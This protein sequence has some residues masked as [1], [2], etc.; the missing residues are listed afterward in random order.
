[1]FFHLSIRTASGLTRYLK[2]EGGGMWIIISIMKFLWKENRIVKYVPE[3]DG[4]TDAMKDLL[5]VFKVRKK[6]IEELERA[7]N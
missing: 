4:V 6:K 1:M 7:Q 3:E 5:T 2:N